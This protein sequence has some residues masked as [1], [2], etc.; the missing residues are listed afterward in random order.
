M[1]SNLPPT[2]ESHCLLAYSLGAN[3]PHR[4]CQMAVMLQLVNIESCQSPSK[5]SEKLKRN[6]LD[7][8]VDGFVLVEWWGAAN[9][10]RL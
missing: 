7:R 1:P 3:F 9:R 10:I 6:S 5:E 2:G 8:K 4:N